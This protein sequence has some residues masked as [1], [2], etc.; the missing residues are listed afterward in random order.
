MATAVTVALATLLLLPQARHKWP[1][2]A[3]FVPAYQTALISIYLLAAYWARSYYQHTRIRSLLWLWS[4]SVYTAG[5]LLAQFLS[6]P[7][8]FVTGVRL[9]G[10]DQT[11]IWLWFFWHLGASGMLLGY[12][13]DEWRT[14]QARVQDP[15]RRFRSSAVLT[16]V[17]LGVTLLSVTALHDLLPVQDIAGDYSRVTS[18][19]YGPLI[20]VLLFSALFFLWR[21]NRF[22]TSMSAW[23]GVAVV[24]LAF[25]NLIT[26][27]GCAR[28]S[29]GWYVG[30]LNALLSAFVLL[31]L[32][33][34]IVHRTYL[35]A[36]ANARALARAKADLERHQ[37]RLELLV[38]ERTR[39]LEEAQHTLLHT[40][41]LEAVGKLTGGVAHDFNNVLHIISGNLDLIRVMATGQDKILARYA[42]ARDAVQR[43][44]RLSSQLLAF[45][46][47]Q[48]LQPAPTAVAKMFA[49]VDELLARA[50][51]TRI[52]I[53][54][55]I[56]PDAWHIHVDR[57]QL[58]SVIL[59]LAL[60]AND[61]IT[62]EGTFTIKVENV[63]LAAPNAA[64]LELAEGDFVRMRFSDTGSGMRSDVRERAFE[65]FFST[66]DV[67]KGTGLG[68]SMAYGFIKQSGGHIA[69]ESEVGQ[70]TTVTILFPRCLD[71]VIEVAPAAHVDIDGGCETI[72]V[73]DD[74]AAIRENVTEML[75]RLGYRV[76]TAASA[77]E[78]WAMLRQRADIDLLFTDVVMPGAM[79][80]TQL[81]ALACGHH[82]RLRVLY[83]SGYAVDGR[84]GSDR[85][86][87]G[88]AMLH[89]PY[90][91]ASL[92]RAVRAALGQATRQ[93][94]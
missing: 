51:G 70:G 10:G 38:R 92:A 65:P 48:V 73:V 44:A 18:T 4:G 24:A 14:P 90:A 86:A 39:S 28:L 37:D 83:T 69:I 71:D 20:Q 5:V 41:K 93:E 54:R 6:L 60:N 15:A 26:M 16:G 50:L 7:G 55:A 46:R 80:S 58:E 81:V 75:T 8:A 66:K 1:A 64:Q 35:Q 94:A 59:N 34:R 82:P 29:V 27:A 25:D 43:G 52:E 3:A 56:A 9:L 12:A 47:K 23:I 17:A 13:V 89:K 77:D 78:A 85:P 57:Q 31:G 84:A 72:L 61:A 53:V 11:T 76:L 45:S 33:M 68:L 42:S 30:R 63:S 2:I 21:G 22:R 87:P 79:T 74:E 40:Q 19:G 62:H 36:T 88:E 32:Y 91:A 67:G 49:D